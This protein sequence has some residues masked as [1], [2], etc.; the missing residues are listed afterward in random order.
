MK[1]LLFAVICLFVTTNTVAQ[2]Y[3]DGH[4]SVT[5]TDS[6]VHDSTDC[7]TRTFVFYHITID[8]SY[9]GQIV[10][11]VDTTSASLI[12]TFVNSFGF[13]PWSFTTNPGGS[14]SGSGYSGSHDFS[15]VGGYAHFWSHVRKIIAGPDTLVA[16]CAHD[17][18]LVTDP[19]EY[20]TVSGN[21]FI[22][23]N[24][25]CIFDAGD[26]FINIPISD[27]KVVAAI[28]PPG[29][30][31]NQSY[32][33]FGSGASYSRNIQKSWVAT[34]TLSIPSYYYFVFATGSCT[35]GPY[36]FTSLPATGADFP[37]QCTSNVDV[38]CGALSAGSVRQFTPFQL[39]PYV[40]NTGCNPASGQMKLILD[41]NVVYSAALSAHPAD[42]VMGD[43]LIWNYSGLTN[44][45]GTGYWNSF[46][47]SIHLTPDATVVAGDTLCFRVLTNIPTAD[48]NPANNDYSF[49]LPVV[50][51]YD[52][53][54]KEVSPRGTGT[55]GNIP[56]SSDTLTYTVH[57]Q[58][59]GTAAAFDVKITDTLDSDIDPASFKI[60]G[61]SHTMTPRWLS[62]NVV[63]FNYDNI[64]LPDSN[65]N[66][67]A[68]HG[69][70]RFSVALKSGLPI[71][72]QIKNT[73]YIYFD[74]NPPVI[75]NTVV[76]T[77]SSPTGI[78]AVPTALSV[79]VYPNPATDNITIENLGGGELTIVNMNG[80]VIIRQQIIKDKA[81]IDVSNL[82][83]GVYI[84]RTS[85][86]LS[87]GTTKFVKY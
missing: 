43:T 14:S 84:L 74:L 2:T 3:T 40:S 25:N 35:A 22:D 69:S 27:I 9:T 18:L 53:N 38:Q 57:F 58:N 82:A 68:S 44:I 49:C 21:K 77:L 4:L 64:N 8:S 13:S 80:V 62:A 51:S 7:T 63:Q 19:C 17:S 81:T 59:T 55:E 29:G 67:P 39:N 76:N 48:I 61:T 28:P 52:P 71:G 72:T 56:G 31:W 36:V 24:G 10:Q 41:P 70:V 78:Q 6:M 73:G 66:E 85:N 54:M 45:S 65:S 79:K 37:F 11:V 1:N 87:S 20:S 15:I 26:D 60:L 12:G 30:G 16:T 83:S 46:M 5:V 23:N 42:I 32:S 34:C 50:Y 47:S 86:N 75:T 33:G